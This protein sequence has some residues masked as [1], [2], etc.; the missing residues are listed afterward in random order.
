MDY[1]EVWTSTCG[2]SKESGSQGEIVQVCTKHFH[3]VS[4]SRFNTTNVMVMECLTYLL[5]LNKTLK[6]GVCLRAL[7]DLH[8][9]F[10]DD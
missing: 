8:M 7:P 4:F 10:T 2:H 1:L 9:R 3:L 6:V 5:T